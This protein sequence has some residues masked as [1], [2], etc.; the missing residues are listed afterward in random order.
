MSKGKLSFMCSTPRAGKSTY[1]K[2]WAAEKP[3]RVVV[4]GDAIR[5]ALH[6]S[7]Y[8]PLA[9]TIVFGM[10]HIFIRSLL[11][12]G[13]DVLF[14]DTNS[15]RISIQRLL[16]ID[17]N[18]TPVF[19]YTPVEVCKQR[20][21]ESGQEDLIEVIDRIDKNI[22]EIQK[23]GFEEFVREI[24]REIKVRGNYECERTT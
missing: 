12:Q 24:V 16:E 14:D 13:Y 2:K 23:V 3:M 5:L 9:E 17:A 1:A 22:K 20:A 19:I 18:A 15:S 11:Q 8:N 4:C 10:Q 7:R 21:I 6:G